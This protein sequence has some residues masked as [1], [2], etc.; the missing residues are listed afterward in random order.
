MAGLIHGQAFSK[1]INRSSRIGSYTAE[2]MKSCSSRGR[3]T[4]CSV[5]NDPSE[6]GGAN[7]TTPGSL[8]TPRPKLRITSGLGF[9]NLVSEALEWKEEVDAGPARKLIDPS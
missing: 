4:A 6:C 9:S 1:Q 2:L 5:R 7:K 8:E 3:Y